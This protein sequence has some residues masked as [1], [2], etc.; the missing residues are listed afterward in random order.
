MK[1]VKTCGVL[2]RVRADPSNITKQTQM[3]SS[4]KFL[5]FCPCAF[6]S[7]RAAPNVHEWN[8][9][10][11]VLEADQTPPIASTPTDLQDKNLK[12]IASHRGSL[13][14]LEGGVSITRHAPKTACWNGLT[15]WPPKGTFEE[16]MVGDDWIA[17]VE[18]V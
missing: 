13:V 1:D 8:A 15:G 17:D 7:L 2:G 14:W 9:I 18:F 10:S 6:G 16:V 12:V 11:A 4:V 5:S 3:A